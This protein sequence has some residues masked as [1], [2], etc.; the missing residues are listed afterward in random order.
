MLNDLDTKGEFYEWLKTE[1]KT[2]VQV[3]EEGI[4]ILN[5]ELNRLY[6]ELK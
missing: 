1:C 2:D 5:E 4:A 3:Y 6:Q